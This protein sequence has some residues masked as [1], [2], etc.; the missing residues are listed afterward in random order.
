MY[1]ANGTHQTSTWTVLTSK[2]L[3]HHGTKA[4]ILMSMKCVRRLQPRVD[5]WQLVSCWHLLQI[6]FRP[7]ASGSVWRDG[8]YWASYCPLDLQVVMALRLGGYRQPSKQS[9]PSFSHLLGPLAKCLAGKQFLMDASMH[10]VLFCCACWGYPR[11]SA[12]ARKG[13]WCIVFIFCTYLSPT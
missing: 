13:Q 11:T 5:S 10:Q 7:S 6:A 9:V 4:C 1:V 2:H 12:V 3:S 8:N